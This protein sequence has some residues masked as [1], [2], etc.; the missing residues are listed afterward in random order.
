MVMPLFLALPS[1]FVLYFLFK[2]KP[3]NNPPKTVARS[4]M[5]KKKQTV[6]RKELAKI[7]TNKN[8]KSPKQ[9]RQPQNP[10]HQFVWLEINILAPFFSFIQHLFKSQPNYKK[11][12]RA[13]EC[14]GGKCGKGNNLTI[15]WCKRSRDNKKKRS[16]RRRLPANGRGQCHMCKI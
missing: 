1:L 13:R 3:H 8:A 16:E 9:Q 5:Q 14:F 6:K 12:F 7:I 11:S 2:T 10:F 4:R 15:C